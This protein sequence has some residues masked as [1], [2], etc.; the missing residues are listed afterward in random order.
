M[1]ALALM[2]TLVLGLPITV[3]ALLAST[4]LVSTLLVLQ[5]AEATGIH[6][7]LRLPVEVGKSPLRLLTTDGRL[8]LQHLLLLA[9]R[10]VR[11]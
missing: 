11:V 2:T 8:P 10:R 3:A 6:Q 7:T 1:A 9:G 4:M 5:V